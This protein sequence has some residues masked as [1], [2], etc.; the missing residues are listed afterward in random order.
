MKQKHAQFSQFDLSES[1][2]KG[3][4]DAGFSEPSPI[5]IEAIPLVLKGRDVVAQAQTGTGKTAA[6]GL[7]LMSRLLPASSVQIL[8]ITPTRELALQVSEEL[9]SLGKHAQA[10]AVSVYGG[11][12]AREQISALKH[13]ANI[14]AGTPGR[15][16]DLM[17]SGRMKIEPSAVVLDEADRML[18]MGFIE[19]IEQIF[20]FLPDA[21]QTL[22]FSAT[23]PERVQKLAQKILSEPVRIRT[24]STETAARIKQKYF[25]VSENEKE[26]ALVRLLEFDPPDRA[27]VFSKTKRE[28]DELS[29]R[30]T[31][32]G[33]PSRPI[34]GDLEQNKRERVLSSFRAG[35]TRLLIATDVAARGLDIPGVS[36]VFNY[37]IPYDAES[38]VHR[39]GRTGRAGQEGV[40]LT[41]VSP[42]EFRSWKRMTRENGGTCELAVIPSA[43]DVRAKRTSGLVEKIAGTPPNHA[44]EALLDRLTEMMDEREVGLR[45]LTMIQNSSEV[46]GP[47]KIGKAISEVH[48]I[49]REEGRRKGGRFDRKG[50]GRFGRNR[51]DR[52]SAHSDRQERDREGRGAGIYS[53]SASHSAKSSHG[54]ALNERSSHD[55]ASHEKSAHARSSHGSSGSRKN[56]GKAKSGK[57]FRKAGPGFGNHAR[58]DRKKKGPKKKH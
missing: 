32:R 9:Q 56:E 31:A 18:D 34:H 2:Q 48:D 16:L 21:R 45:L 7:P 41:L 37:H 33:I 15:L 26:A 38:Y 24:Q 49:A 10:K 43:A 35:T 25:V 44:N 5:Q 28:A 52:A 55:K 6:F 50:G 14:V 29:V 19:D 57:V 1:I 13:G 3:I 20:E 51:R 58:K 36:H 39:I 17:S 40:A 12:S 23:L 22:L 54:K 27:I 47:E 8:V 30:L 42:G 46:E 4:V 53:A 11:A